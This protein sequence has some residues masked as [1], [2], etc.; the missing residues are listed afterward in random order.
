MKYFITC[1][2]ISVILFTSLYA[3]QKHSTKSKTENATVEKFDPKSDPAKDLKKAIAEA[4]KTNRR[5]LFDVGGEWCIW[6]HRLDTLF[7]QHADVAAYMHKNFV[8]VKINVSK[9]NENKEFL[10]TYPEIKGY[11]HLFVLDKNGKFLYSKDTGELES[12]KHHDPDKVMAFL[13][14]WSGIKE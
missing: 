1:L 4:T 7:M 11:P 14:E 6:C 12:G 3:G 10:S 2:C 8:V 13:K 5:I 9:E